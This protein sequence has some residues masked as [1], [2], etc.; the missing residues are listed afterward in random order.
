MAGREQAIQHRIHNCQ[1]GDVGHRRG[2]YAAQHAAEIDRRALAGDERLHQRIADAIERPLADGRDGVEAARVEPLD[3]LGGL[4]LRLGDF[5]RRFGLGLGVG[6]HMIVGVGGFP[7]N[8]HVRVGG[9]FERLGEFLFCR[10]AQAGEGDAGRQRAALGFQIVQ[11][12]DALGVFLA[13]LRL[14]IEV[15]RQIPQRDGGGDARGLAGLLRRCLGVGALQFAVAAADVVLPGQRLAQLLVGDARGFGQPGRHVA[16]GT[17][18]ALGRDLRRHLLLPPQRR[19]N[20]AVG[21]LAL[22]RGDGGAGGAQGAG[23]L[24]HECSEGLRQAGDPVEPFAKI[25]SCR[26]QDVPRAGHGDRHLVEFAAD[27]F[28]GAQQGREHD[29]GGQL[30]F[31]AHLPKLA[32]AD[33]QLARQGLRENGHVFEQAAQLV[34]LEPPRCKSLAE[35][36]GGSRRFLH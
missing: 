34:T 6:L 24:L 12:A 13:R 22:I 2:N 7:G 11:R 10:G 5:V 16:I 32:N 27:L 18:A 31:A 15:G 4:G 9:L 33:T 36:H 25:Q 29:V 3:F 30:A 8:P 28:R 26:S 20:G 23:A 21:R 19:R 1:L 14:G 35:L 17:G